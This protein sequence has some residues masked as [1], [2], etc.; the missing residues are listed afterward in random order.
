MYT[1]GAYFILRIIL[2]ITIS[3]V[4]SF[5]IYKSKN[6]G[7]KNI[8]NKWLFGIRWFAIALLLLILFNPGIK[9][10]NT[11]NQKPLIYFLE[12]NSSSIKNLTDSSDLA[13]Y[14]K[15]LNN[16]KNELSNI[17]D[18][19][20]FYFDGN[21]YSKKNQEFSGALTDI[22]NALKRV[23]ELND[24]QVNKVVLLSDGNYNQG[25]NPSFLV[26]TL[27]YQLYAVAIGDTLSPVSFYFQ[28]LFHNMVGY[29]NEEIPLEASIRYEE[30]SKDTIVEIQI[31][32]KNKVLKSD[33]V[34]LTK[35]S[36]RT[37]YSSHFSSK[38]EGLQK[39]TI[40]IKG[41]PESSRSFYIEIKQQKQQV[42]VL[43]HSV[44]PDIGVIYRALSE[45]NRFEP[46][47]M[48]AN[49]FNKQISDYNLI[50]FHQI[51]SGQFSEDRYFAEAMTAQIPT[52]VILG[53]QSD[54]STFNQGQ[55]AL[56]LTNFNGQ[57]DEAG[58]N[59][60]EDF[61]W[62]KTEFGADFN[63]S[64]W[65]P[66]T[67]PFADYNIKKGTSLFYQNLM[68]LK[69]DRPA[70]LFVD[71]PFRYAI[72]TGTGIWKWGIYDYRNSSNHNRI[73]DLVY[74]TVRFLSLN[75][76][77]KRLQLNVESI[78]ES[79]DP[80]EIEAL[81]YNQNYMPYNNLPGT[82][83]LKDSINNEYVFDFIP[84]G[85]KY[86]IEPGQLPAGTYKYK[87]YVKSE[88][89]TFS[90]EGRFI[91]NETNIES[92]NY[93]T[94]MNLMRKLSGRDNFLY[95]KDI[96]ELIN[97][98]KPDK[99][100]QIIIKTETRIADLIDLKLLLVLIITLFAVEWAIRKYHGQL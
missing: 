15:K 21:V 54:L 75:K 24:Q 53:P 74:K 18:V 63:A 4:L 42:L 56:Q 59:L 41:V 65:P 11:I 7:K 34:R 99:T 82:M 77:K 3:F 76:P 5:V 17:Y 88:T 90:D 100:G 45:S 89:E 9:I 29:T 93:K 68:G 98:L 22:G 26:S 61:S 33:E 12:D 19:K 27:P 20:T 43:Y 84:S 64:T 87:A 60:N 32:S 81:W 37:S 25:E 50:I 52:W 51:P 48:Q 85:N 13:K 71:Q 97:L 47:I 62:F 46:V 31:W 69:S 28:N 14:S 86:K 39:F 72:L 55:N 92:S 49:E 95:Y 6:D 58:I 1:F 94:N 38:K 67:V 36:R 66:L 78:Y 80:I 40:R 35:K 8:I 83:V 16:I 57:F 70:W 91:V 23:T 30:L 10:S 96:D 79:V 44:H 73:N 2:S